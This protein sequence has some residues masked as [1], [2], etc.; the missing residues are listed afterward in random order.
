[1]DE[2]HVVVRHGEPVIFFSKEISS[3]VV[4]KQ[5]NS[6][7]SVPLNKQNKEGD[8]ADNA[9]GSVGSNQLV[10]IVNSINIDRAPLREDVLQRRSR[11]EGKEVVLA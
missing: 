6:D 10:I 1:M 3:K 8:E 4:V 9:S 2:L 11:K 7:H 5:Q